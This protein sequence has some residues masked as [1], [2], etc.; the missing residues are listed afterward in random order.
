MRPV[1]L[2]DALVGRRVHVVA[3]DRRAGHGQLQARRRRGPL[4]LRATP[5]SGRRRAASSW[6]DRSRSS[7]TIVSTAWPR[8]SAPVPI[9]RG[10]ITGVRW[11]SS[12]LKPELGMRL[13]ELVEARRPRRRR[14]R[15]SSGVKRPSLALVDQHDLRARGILREAALEQVLADHARGIRREEPD[16]VV[17][18]DLVPA[19][20]DE[21]QRRRPGRASRGRRAR[22]D[23]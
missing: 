22:G 19:R 15:R 16:I 7:E 5:G 10:P 3:D 14:S 4:R 12:F 20:G 8:P 23:G 18:G 9:S 11:V 2:C 13:G 17:L 6:R 21:P 1:V